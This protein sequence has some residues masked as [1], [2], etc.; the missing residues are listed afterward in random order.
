[1]VIAKKEIDAFVRKTSYDL[2]YLREVSELHVTC[3]M[4]PRRDTPIMVEAGDCVLRFEGVAEFNTKTTL[5][6]QNHNLDTFP[7]ITYFNIRCRG[8]YCGATELNPTDTSALL[9]RAL[10]QNDFVRVYADDRLCCTIVK[11]V[12]SRFPFLFFVERTLTRIKKEGKVID[13]VG[14]WLELNDYADKNPQSFRL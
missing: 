1:M 12:A 2:L 14:N 11:G 3:D 5:R 10:K 9:H 13:S 8:I 6:A 7:P 4:L